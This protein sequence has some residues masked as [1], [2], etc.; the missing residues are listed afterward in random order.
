MCIRDSINTDRVSLVTGTPNITAGALNSFTVNGGDILITGTGI[1]ANAQ[2][3]LDLVSR[4]VTIDG[5][6]NA[7]ELN[8][9]AGRN[10]WSHASGATSTYFSPSWAG[11]SGQCNIFRTSPTTAGW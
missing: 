11:W 2:Q 4:S 1:N 9:V 7:P 10:T 8:I 5:R 6:V 3:I